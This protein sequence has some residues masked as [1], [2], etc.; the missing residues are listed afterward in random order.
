MTPVLRTTHRRRLG[1]GRRNHAPNQG[2]CPP[3]ERHKQCGGARSHNQEHQQFKAAIAAIGAHLQPI[4]N[5]IHVI[6]PSISSDWGPTLSV[7]QG[8]T[9][10]S[11]ARVVRQVHKAQYRPAP[12][13]L[14]RIPGLLGAILDLARGAQRNSIAADL[15]AAKTARQEYGMEQFPEVKYLCMGDIDR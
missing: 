2:S 14:S 8:R 4:F 10:R 6:P 7:Y 11:N 12:N 13:R 9:L 1:H 3:T 15:S 5:P